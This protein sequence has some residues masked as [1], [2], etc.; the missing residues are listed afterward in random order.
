M[1]ILLRAVATLCIAAQ[2]TACGGGG[3]G[4][5]SNTGSTNP[6][7]PTP[8][9][10]PATLA[11]GVIYTIPAN[12]TVAVPAGT[13]V[14]SPSAQMVTIDRTNGNL[15]IQAAGGNVTVSAFETV[16]TQAGVVITVPSTATGSANSIVTTATPGNN[17]DP[18]TTVQSLAGSTSSNTSQNINRTDGTGSAATFWG[19]TQM[20][21][22]ANGNILIADSGTLR[23]V[24]QAGIVTTL[25]PGGVQA[26]WNGVAT[27][28]VGNIYGSGQDPSFVSTPSSTW[29]ASIYELPVSGTTQTLFADWDTSSGPFVGNGGLVLDSKGNLFLADGDNNRIV[30]FTPG[31]SWAVFAGSGV[32]G[33]QDGVGTTATF[34]FN[35]YTGIV[36]DANDNLYV[37]SGITIRKI[38]PDATVSTITN[39]LTPYT[40]AIALDPSGNLY[41]TGFQTIYRVSSTSGSI[42]PFAFTNTADPV[43]TMTADSNGNLYLGT[44]GA[45]SQVF[46]V[47][48]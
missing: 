38:A 46:K 34:S 19:P 27:D 18:S 3:G 9:S 30:K 12:T 41:V 23:T 39:Q 16:V 33:D 25:A 47:S 32:A 42:T 2:L 36:I 5:G 21:M 15:G 20:T 26:G 28:K 8:P 17:T 6:S 22:E 13:T 7:N 24:T 10:T 44:R 40:G 29:A 43:F 11:P 4:G 45:G 48:F 35:A 1:H 37:K 31:G 14:S